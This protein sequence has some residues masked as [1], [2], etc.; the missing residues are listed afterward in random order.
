MEQWCQWD[1][2]SGTIVSLENAIVVSTMILI[3]QDKIL[4]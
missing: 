3:V 2:S 1:N 4:W